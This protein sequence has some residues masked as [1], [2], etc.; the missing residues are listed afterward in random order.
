MPVGPNGCHQGPGEA[1]WAS[2]EGRYPAR[3]LGHPVP[4]RTRGSGR[5][6]ASHR[7]LRWRRQI[8]GRPGCPGDRSPGE[9]QGPATGWSGVISASGLPWSCQRAGRRGSPQPRSRPAR[10]DQSGK[11]TRR[12]RERCPANA[13]TGEIHAIRNVLSRLRPG[14]VQRPAGTNLA[15]PLLLA[16]QQQVSHPTGGSGH[17]HGREPT[18]ESAD[19]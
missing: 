8:E 7:H 3:D 19:V 13:G 6:A 12:R 9:L 4:S 2:S 10:R 16:D 14:P 5:Q 1:R 15:R 11:D 18:S 17:G